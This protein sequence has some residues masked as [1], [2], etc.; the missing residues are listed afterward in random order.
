MATLHISNLTLTIYNHGIFVLMSAALSFLLI[1]WRLSLAEASRSHHFQ[2][3]SSNPV[4]PHSITIVGSGNFGSAI[5]RLLGRNVLRSPK[6]FRSE[7]RMWVFEEELDD[8]RKLSDVINADHENVKYL[9]GIQLPTNVRAVPDLSDA[10]RNAS[11]VVFV[12]P[13]QFLPSCKC[14]RGGEEK[15]WVRRETCANM[16]MK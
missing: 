15:W 9:P 8:G 3:P 5:A 12:L 6:H 13:H 2:G 10:V 1:V 11:I 7:V 4:K 14:V 16:S